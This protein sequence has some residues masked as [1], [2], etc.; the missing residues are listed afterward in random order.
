MRCSQSTHLHV[1]KGIV[2]FSGAEGVELVPGAE[3]AL[4]HDRVGRRRA[5]VVL[6]QELQQ[7]LVVVPCTSKRFARCRQ[8]C[9]LK[10]ILPYGRKNSAA[11]DNLFKNYLNI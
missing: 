2:V 9:L 4:H 3:E 7:V 8:C 11:V 1:S 10:I 6:A 5:H